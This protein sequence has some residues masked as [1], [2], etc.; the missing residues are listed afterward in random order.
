[1]ATGRSRVRGRQT[2][3]RAPRP[4][5]CPAMTPARLLDPPDQSAIAEIAR[6]IGHRDG[7]GPGDG[8]GGQ[9]HEHIRPVGELAPERSAPTSLRPCL[10]SEIL[11]DGEATI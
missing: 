1:M 8:G 7:V 2:P 11:R 10:K 4:I 9:R 3:T 6:S 5:P